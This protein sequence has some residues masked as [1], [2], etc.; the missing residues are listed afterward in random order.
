M[1]ELYDTIESTLMWGV[2][3]FAVGLVIYLAYR[4]Y[5]KMKC[6]RMRRRHHAR[7]AMRR[8][9]SSPEQARLGHDSQGPLQQSTGS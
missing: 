3:I 5:R 9:D 8:R 1:S 2:V 4:Q 6:R 7:R